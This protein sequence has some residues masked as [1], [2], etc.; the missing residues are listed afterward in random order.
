MPDPMSVLGGIAASVQLV[1]IAAKLSHDIYISFRSVQSAG[2]DA[3]RQLSS[4]GSLL[5]QH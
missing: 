2:A 1:D 3:Q 5:M 4:R